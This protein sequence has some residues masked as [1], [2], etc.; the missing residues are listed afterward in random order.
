MDPIIVEFYQLLSGSVQTVLRDMEWWQYLIVIAD[1]T[2]K[3]IALGWVPKDRRPSSAMAWL[4]AIFL[5]PF[6]GLLL[7]FLMGSPYINRRR[8][9]IQNRANELIR[10][11]SAEEPETPKNM[12]LS[13]EIQSLVALN[14]E[15]TALPPVAG[16]MVALHSDYR[17]SIKAMASAI[18]K[19]KYFVNVEMYIAAYDSTTAPFFD[20]MERA[21]KRGVDVRFLWDHIGAHKYPGNKKLGKR[22]ERM[23]VQ[24]EVMLPLKPWRW[25]FRRPD[26]R[27]HRKLVIV[28]GTWAFMGSQNLV[29]PEYQNK[30]NH[31]V[32]RQW[33][34]V[35]AEITGPVVSSIN[36][37]F[38]VDW[39][40]ESG[41]TLDFMTPG[42]LTAWLEDDNSDVGTDVMQ[43][44]PSGPGFTT[45]PNLRLFNS[46]IHHAK[47]SLRIVS[48]Y[49]I[50]DESLLEA[51]TTACYRGVTVELYVSE[52]SD[53]KM[54]GHAQASYYQEL[55]DA[56]VKMYLYPAPYVLHS[57]FLIADEEVA[58]MGSSNM[59][60]RSFW[61]N[62]E[63]SLMVGD[64][65]MLESLNELAQD[66]K[67]K[68]TLL[69]AE[70]WNTRPWYKQYVDNLCRLTSALQ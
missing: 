30:K 10:T 36:S 28:D 65:A 55:L 51:V 43:V 58:V 64:G 57:K 33:V 5:L 52:K 34:D 31:K 18:D 62:Y 17:E 7:Y 54:V 20:A 61:L 29:E 3:F 50:P 4:L 21:A 38:A 69:T 15:L 14:R 1:Y 35:M 37:V 16:S 48:P 23:G 6:V 63:C 24:Y 45:E 32:G 9:T 40:T 68:S 56:G 42:E 26:L 60:M 53:Q 12:V 41:E 47:K 22:L 66:Y 59:D 8:H 2:L 67:D 70:E 39:Y 27:N 11:M 13:R 46:L 19:A 49:F 25:R 44:V